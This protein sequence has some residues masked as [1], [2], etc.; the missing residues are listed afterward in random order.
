MYC[1]KQYR[2]KNSHRSIMPEKIASFL[3]SNHI[4][5]L[6]TC[7]ESKPYAASCFYAYDAKEYA[8]IFASSTTTHHMQLIAKNPNVAGTIALCEESLHTIQGVQ[9]RGVVQ[10]ASKEQERRYLKRFPIAVAMQ[11]TLWA[12]RLSWVKMTDNRL[13]FK[14]KISWNR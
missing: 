14:T 7:S 1:Q 2:Y 10:K 8:L 5:S 12:L 9:L 11:P 3:A 13:G 4:L 6:A